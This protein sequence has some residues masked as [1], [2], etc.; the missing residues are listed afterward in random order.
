M[1]AGHQADLTEPRLEAASAWCMKLADGQLS[2]EDDAAFANWLDADP[3]NRAAFDRVTQLW[4]QM[5]MFA[6][7]PELIQRRTRALTEFQQA[8]RRRWTRQI[9]GRWRAVASLAAAILV[10]VLT[11]HLWLWP[12]PENYRTDRGERR[13]FVLADGSRLTLDAASHVKVRLTDKRR[14]L[15]L[16]EGRARFDVAKDASRPF[17]VTAGDKVVVATGTS[18]SVERVKAQVQVVL[19]EGQVMVYDPPPARDVAP[20]MKPEADVLRPGQ[21]LVSSPTDKAETI[22][23]VDLALA[24]SWESGQLTFIDEPLALAV[25]RMNRYADTKLVTQDLQ[26]GKLLVNGVYNAGDIEAF[27]VGVTETLP[28]QIERRNDE[29]LLRRAG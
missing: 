25:E 18:F 3:E 29:I 10:A 12:L 27:L 22:A 7:A 6:T 1:S 5:G 28:V 11:F 20:E 13:V 15:W 9:T 26:T 24:R 19:Y 17:S 2:P 14:E 23:A 8:N 4:Q 21:Q 16:T